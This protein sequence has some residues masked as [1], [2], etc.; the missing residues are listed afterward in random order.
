[1]FEFS[2]IMSRLR[3]YYGV[4]TN[5]EVASKLNIDYN[6]IKGWGS[7]K[8]VAISTIIELL[9]DEPINLTWLVHGK[10]NMKIGESDDILNALTKIELVLQKDI[11]P[12]IIDRISEDKN[13]QK[14][15]SLLEYAPDEFIDQIISRLEEFKK[16]SEI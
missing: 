7:R 6:T 14:L 5:T 4:K 8:K 2:K 12:K 11:D 9:G 16:L 10:G 15:L 3:N 1:M 13:L